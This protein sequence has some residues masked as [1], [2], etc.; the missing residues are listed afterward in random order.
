[1]VKYEVESASQQACFLIARFHAGF[2]RTSRQICVRSP[3]PRKPDWGGLK[4]AASNTSQDI[5]FDSSFYEPYFCSDSI[6]LMHPKEVTQT[7]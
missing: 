6:Q 5:G 1:M 7:V 2:L 3:A 4:C